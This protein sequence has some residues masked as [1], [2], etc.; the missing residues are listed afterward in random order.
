[1]KNKKEQCIGKPKLLQKKI[2]KNRKEKD[3]LPN[4]KLSKEDW[5]KIYDRFDRYFQNL[6]T[7][8]EYAKEFVE[9]PF[10]FE[11]TENI[12]I[13]KWSPDK[14]AGVISYLIKYPSVMRMF[15]EKALFIMHE[16]YHFEKTDCASYAG[17]VSTFAK[18]L[19]PKNDVVIYF[20]TVIITKSPEKEKV[21]KCTEHF[22]VTINGKLF[23]NSKID[24]FSYRNYEAVL[25][26]TDFMSGNFDFD[27]II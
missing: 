2:V 23:D 21:G 3:S 6:H 16:K 17:F 7:W 11:N 13:R 8:Q 12:D 10:S 4:T 19:N 25:Q 27:K 18:L 5:D 15:Y 9:T 22:W 14:K 1:M 26:S 20:G 24:G